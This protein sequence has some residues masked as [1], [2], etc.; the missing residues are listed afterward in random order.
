MPTLAEKISFAERHIRT[1]EGV[2]FSLKGREW[3]RD[4]FWKAA[5]GFKLW[6]APNRDPCAEC[7]VRIGEIV[8]TPADNDTKSCACGG[9]VSEPILVTVLILDRGDGKT[10]NLMAYSMATMFL[11]RGKSIAALWAAEDQG[12][13]IFAEN[14][15]AAIDRAPPLRSRCEIAGTPPILSVP[16]QAS[17]LEV[18]AAS[19]RSVT[20]RRRTHVIVDEARDVEA[21]TLMALLPST[22]AVGGVEC[23]SGHVQLT[24]EDVARMGNV[25]TTCSACGKPLAEWW[26]RIILASATGV[27]GGTERDWLHELQELLEAT[28]HPNYHL[29]TAAAYG[30]SLN[31]RKNEKV[32]GAIEAVFGQLPSTKHYTAAEYGG[33]WTAKGEDVLTVADVK[34][35]MDPNLENEE[36]SPN[37]CVGFL[38][39]STTVEKTSLVIL[40]DDAKRS[41]HPYEHV[42][43]SYLDFWWPGH[44]KQKAA[45]RVPDADVKRTIEAVVPMYRG[46][47]TLEIDP[48]AGG[49][50]EPEYMWPIIMLKELRQGA[51]DWRRKLRVWP[52]RADLSDVGWDLFIARVHD[53]TIRLQFCQ[54]ILDEIKG[55]MLQRSKYSDRKPTVTDRNRHV[56][57]RDIT[58][59]IA[60]CCWLAQREEQRSLRGSSMAAMLK[61]QSAATKEKSDGDRTHG[62]MSVFG[63]KF[64]P[65]SF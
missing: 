43:L 61:R 56:M 53:H 18:L 16:K 32:S 39:T 36:G 13:Q 23:P 29:F 58:Q 2:P 40:A 31:P 41:S 8:E 46:L 60:C 12:S 54:E 44:G 5:D 14:W 42:Y 21:K 15:Q 3:V 17:M 34:A 22:N 11:G 26:P 35:V 20:G 38:D 25:P 52:N 65:D 48:K 64:G 62:S 55:I 50:A 4:Q 47:S 57:H 49:K 30:R 9:L 6:R 10:F 7:A 19:A 33:G 27:I 45:R 51:G 63:G 28:P 37:R 24:P 1:K 59:A